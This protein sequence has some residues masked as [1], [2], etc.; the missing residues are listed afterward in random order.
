MVFPWSFLSTLGTV[1]PE[2]FGKS[3]AQAV[4]PSCDIQLNQLP[5]KAFIG[6]TVSIEILQ[7]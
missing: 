4:V 1:V 5:P 7:K 6:D 3:F 2:N